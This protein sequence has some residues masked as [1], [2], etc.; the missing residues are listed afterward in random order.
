MVFDISGHVPFSRIVL[1]QLNYFCVSGIRAEIPGMPE[2]VPGKFHL[3][4]D[5]PSPA[6]PGF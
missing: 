6:R 1:I 2:N 4:I 3:T 5:A